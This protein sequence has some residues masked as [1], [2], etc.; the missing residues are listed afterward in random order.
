MD[1]GF[2]VL[3]GQCDCKFEDLGT[4]FGREHGEERTLVLWQSGRHRG[5]WRRRNW[6]QSTRT[7]EQDVCFGYRSW[8]RCVWRISPASVVPRARGTES[9]GCGHEARE[10]VEMSFELWFKRVVRVFA[11]EAAES[12]D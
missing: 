5:F 4:Y 7:T 11:P 1:L 3:H 12:V 2:A 6:C 10:A 9:R 8:K